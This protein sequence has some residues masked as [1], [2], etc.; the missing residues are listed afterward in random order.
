VASP[1]RP[2][3]W[4]LEL[5]HYNEKVRWALDYKRI[6][7]VRRSLP[8]GLHVVIAKRKWG[9]ATTPFLTIG[10]EGI[11]DSTRIIAA[12]E[13]RWPEPALYPEDADDRRRALELEEFFDEELGPH[14]RRAL[15]MELLLRSD[16][17]LPLFTHGQRPAVRAAIRATFPVLRVGMR[18]Y[19]EIDE[20]SSAYSREK[21]RTVLDRLEHEL[22][23]AQYLVGDSFTVAD[24]TAASLFYPLVLPPEYPYPTLDAPPPGR[25]QEFIAELEDRPGVAWVA[26]MYRRHRLRQEL[27]ERDEAIAAG[28]K[29]GDDL[30]DRIGGRGRIGRADAVRDD[31]RPRPDP[32]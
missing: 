3:L 24:L 31:D 32:V 5:S 4:Q 18:R 6:P 16:L 27:P 29:G 25:A 2:V 1:D 13:Q 22:D 14:I 12:L 28:T 21:M 9:G 23:G 30:G 17:L 15:Y 19:F 26:E 11:G 20:E 7:H 8:P 10:D